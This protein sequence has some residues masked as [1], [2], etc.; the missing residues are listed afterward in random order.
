MPGFIRNNKPY[1]ALFVGVS[2]M[3]FAAIFIKSANA[4]GLVTVFYRMTIASI[5]IFFP[6]YLNIRKIKT[7]LNRKGLWLAILAGIFFGIDLSFWS[8]GV[9]LINNA[10]LPTLFANLAPVW[11]G[12]GAMLIFKEKPK[13]NFWAGVLV[14]L[15]GMTL[16]IFNQLYGKGNLWK[17]IVLGSIAGMFYAA[18]Y[19][20]AQKGRMLL[21]TISFLFIS[22]LSS[23]L[24]IFLFMLISGYSFFEY[25]R[26]SYLM[27]LGIGLGGQVI[28]WY[29]INYAQ[30]FLPATIVAPT[31]LLQP[32]ITAT[33]AIL[34]LKERLTMLQLIAGLIIIVGIY[35]VN[36]KK[37][38]T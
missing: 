11:V 18:F 8:T 36:Y 7:P 37:H 28:A 12:F 32:I 1:L 19:L 6:F 4:P 34:I 13:A 35:L 24:I 26:H 22:T 5:V 16:F 3:G 25:D 21:N 14:A 10:T 15:L 17:G 9:V 33:M 23:A 38:K 31:L 29:M 27:F 20:V 2:F 30:G